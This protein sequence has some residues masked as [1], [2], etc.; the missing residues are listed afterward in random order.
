MDRVFFPAL[1]RLFPE[2]L[3]YARVHKWA[4][5][6]RVRRA[7]ADRVFYAHFEASTTIARDALSRL[8]IPASEITECIERMRDRL[9]SASQ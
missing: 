3:V 7:G 8:G 9:Y 2:M 5:I 4:D 1:K 6:T